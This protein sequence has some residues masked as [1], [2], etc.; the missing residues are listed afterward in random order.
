VF[1][2][3]RP[4]LV[5]RML[6]YRALSRAA[7]FFFLLAGIQILRFAIAAVGILAFFLLRFYRFA[8]LGF[9]WHENLQRIACTWNSIEDPLAWARPRT[10][11][12]KTSRSERRI[13]VPFGREG[14]NDVVCFLSAM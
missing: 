7:I 8:F 9:F 6:L 2:S 14:M 13:F 11:L 12:V 4:A 3:T 5:V 10:R 1:G